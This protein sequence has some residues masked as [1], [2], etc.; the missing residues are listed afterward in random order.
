MQVHSE[1]MTGGGCYS[2]DV[3]VQDTARTCMHAFKEEDEHKRTRIQEIFRPCS[4][5]RRSFSSNVLCSVFASRCHTDKSA[6]IDFTPTLKLA[7][8]LST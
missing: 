1:G 8:I 2:A 6:S 5:T 4:T 7:P 3:C